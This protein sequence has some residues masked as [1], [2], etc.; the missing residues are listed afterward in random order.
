[1]YLSYWSKLKISYWDN[2]HAHFSLEFCWFFG[3]MIWS[4]NSNINKSTNKNVILWYQTLL[5]ILMCTSSLN[6][7]KSS[8]YEQALS[9][10]RVR[11]FAT[12]RSVAL[13][14]PP[15]MGF[16]RQEHWSEWPCPP[17]GDLPEP[18]TELV[19][20]SPALDGQFF[21]TELAWEDQ[22]LQEVGIIG[23]SLFNVRKL[24]HRDV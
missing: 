9:L 5:W 7:P 2:W 23:I 19:P 3:G 24:R 14:A 21:T 8:K 13:Q 20:V 17:P 1:M 12:P 10:S 18:G 11:L 16:S 4:N 6:P 22:Q 15:S